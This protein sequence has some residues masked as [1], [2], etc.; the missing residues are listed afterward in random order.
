MEKLNAASDILILLSSLDQ[1]VNEAIAQQFSTIHV[2][3]QAGGRPARQVSP[4]P[5]NNTLICQTG[6][7]GKYLGWLDIDWQPS[8]TWGKA[9]GTEEKRLRRTA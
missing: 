6:P 7:R 4:P 3:V 1:R 8:A 9:G 5:G 2:L